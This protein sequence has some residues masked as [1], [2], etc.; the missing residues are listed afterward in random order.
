MNRVT[1]ILRRGLKTSFLCLVALVAI[2]GMPTET[3][4]AKPSKKTTA[5]G[6]K[7]SNT[8]ATPDFAFPQ[9]VEKNASAEFGKAMAQGDGQTALRAA[10]QLDV[11]TGLVSADTYA[12]SLA[13]FDS[14]ARTMPAPYAALARLLEARLYCDIYNSQSWVFNGR[15][16]PA[17]PVPDNVMEWSTPMF[18]EAVTSL[19]HEAMAGAGDAASTPLKSIDPL[20]TD[21]ADAERAGFS[22]LDFMTLQGADILGTFGTSR[23]SAELPFGRK[24]R[25]AQTPAGLAMSLVDDA[26]ARHSGDSDLFIKS[27]FCNARLGLLD[28]K[29]RRNYLKKCVD[30]FIDTPYCARF[31]ADYYSEQPVEETVSL[32]TA[33]DSARKRYD[34][35]RAYLDKYPDAP[36]IGDIESILNDMRSKNV[37]VSFPDRML[38]GRV[39]SA[40]VTGANSY[41][42]HV[43][44]LALKGNDSEHRY[45]YAD[46]KSGGEIVADIP[47]NVAGATPDRF[48]TRIEIPV[49]KPGLYTIVASAN[50]TKSGILQKSQRRQLPV[51]SISDLTVIKTEDARSAERKMYVVSAI[52][53]KP[54]AGAKVTFYKERNGVKTSQSVT[55][56]DSNGCVSVPEGE[57][58]YIVRSGGSMVSGNY[59]RNSPMGKDMNVYLRGSAFTD[60]S[61]YRPGDKVQFS[62]VA[63]TEQ[64]NS[65]KAAAGRRL[66]VILRDAN[67]QEVDTLS[68]ETD[69]LGRA[70]GSFTLPKSGLLGNWSVTVSE[71][72]KWVCNTSMQVAEY[73][74]PT[75]MVT[76]DS[77]AG[78]YKAGETLLFGGE[79][80]TYSGMP[81]AGGK[82]AY[83]VEYVPMWWRMSASGANYGG[84]TETGADG[85]FTIELPTD[86]LVGTEYDRGTYR[87]KVSVTDAAGETREAQAV[88]FSLGNE[89]HILAKLPDMIQADR[90][91]VKYD[92][93]VY[94]MT[95]RPVVK[96]IYYDITADGK[97]VAAGEFESPAFSPELTSVPSG[98]YAFR[99]SLT[100]D[101]KGGSDG[102]VTDSVTVW[103][104]D[105]RR[106]PVRTPLWVPVK[107]ITVPAGEKKVAVR[108][109]SSYDDSWLLVQVSDSRHVISNKWVKVSDGIV[110]IDVDAP[111]DRERVF[112][113]LTGMRDLDMRSE[114][115]TVIPHAQTV[116]LDIKAE[117][118][119]DRI[120]PGAKETWKFRFSTDG[121]PAAGIAD[122]AVMSNKALN[123]LA[124]FQWNF[125]PMGSLYWGNSG[126]MSF[127]SIYQ[128][129]SE[130]YAAAGG[131]VTRTPSFLTPEWNTYGY[132]LYQSGMRAVNEMKYM[133]TSLRV[134]G[135]AKMMDAGADSVAATE[136][137]P[138]T[139]ANSAMTEGVEE[140]VMAD[141]ADMGG[142]SAPKQGGE[143][144]RQ[145]EC[146]LAFFM[147][148]LSTDSQGVS[149]LEFT[150]PNFVGT[151][152][153]QVL[154]YTPEM[155]GGVLTLDAVSAKKV[156]AQ[157]NAPRFAR[158]GDLLSVSATIYNNT[159]SADEVSGRLEFFNPMT[160]ETIQMFDAEAEQVKASGSRVVTT[161]MRI[162]S[163]IDVLGIRVYGE[164]P[165]HTDGEQT[166]IPV[167]PSSTP[168]IESTPFYI[169]P[170]AKDFSVKLPKFG[171][172]SK[173]TLTYSDN[174]VWECV[175][176]LPSITRPESVNILSHAEALYGNAVASGL[177]ARYPQ[178]IEGI[179]EMASPVNAADSS[180]YSPLQKNAAL[181]TVL[182]NNTPWVNDAKAETARMQ[183]LTEYADT[184]SARA[185]VETI[186]KTIT[187]RQNSDGGWS[188]CPEMKSSEFITMRVLGTF[189]SLANMGYLPDGADR[190][191]KKG[192][193][194]VDGCLA[195]DW[196]RSERKYIPVSTLLEYLYEKSAFKGIGATSAFKPLEAAAMKEISKNW[197]DFGIRDKATAAMLLERRGETKLARLILESLR[198]FA[199]V[200]AEKG[201]WYDNLRSGHDGMGTLLM[202]ARVLEAYAMLEPQSESVDLLR[203]WFVVTKQTQNWGDR[204]A[205]AEA[206]QA[207]LASGSEWTATSEAPLITLGG[208]RVDT[209]RVSSVTGSFTVDLDAEAASDKELCVSRAGEGPAWGGVLSQYIAPITEVKAADVPQ[210][211]IAKSIYTI[212]PG[213][214]GNKASEGDLSTGDRVRV[215]LT[216]TC[217]RDLE[218][219][220][221]TDPR[222]ACLEPADQISSYTQS[223]GVWFYRE[224]RD[225]ATNLFIPFLSKGTHV[226][227]Y[228]CLTDRSGEY[229]LGVANA[230]SQYAPTITAHS[231]GSLISVK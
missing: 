53:Q 206:I 202:T 132:M 149:T 21:A 217:D 106:P 172:G 84:E 71:G 93:A 148:G 211:S 116:R 114:T 81:V 1:K 124:P 78:S 17:T 64:D 204:T 75:F 173:V 150:A 226:I 165:G 227:S 146:P 128:V 119:R 220:A 25:E 90:E 5:R 225:S 58:S 159:G 95:G 9:T 207:V 44:V 218:Y 141:D 46:L 54:V 222:A 188:W 55:T 40:T 214:A 151:W 131:K 170:A 69:R 190:L 112:V 11:A 129:S 28:G 137:A 163:D 59:Y 167:L 182:L 77:A 3:Y 36:G 57:I 101:L 13:R 135:A 39:N 205:S 52:N 70:S 88:S 160:G 147:P 216:I 197:R 219:V 20:L 199:S 223:D 184:E 181:K 24:A 10:I 201:M 82:V 87:L 97:S 60:L 126:R 152:Q 189:A 89:L 178:L 91:E 127:K 138:A 50:G 102:V 19:V 86:G 213:E 183:S 16:L 229:T 111:A 168:V 33:N 193:A 103:R 49:L 12:A 30:M 27:Y 115:V 118:F 174:P 104:A 41:G 117:T 109:G 43:L 113:T 65:L 130:Y 56:T 171:N 158:T 198:Q 80:K 125:D 136:M 143:P 47:V 156:M 73:K 45:T 22:V 34:A 63:Y 177:F 195:E 155:R 153:L 14:V 224:V 123:A 200:S 169:A 67:W 6:A 230:Q 66:S 31:L 38:P 228:D 164:I 139:G 134:R 208:K 142:S 96:K 157:L 215:T 105:D 203:Q 231:A 121:R 154:G 42:F 79:A 110:D 92:V 85:R 23:R 26:I 48:E 187:E 98:R 68:V 7:V 133:S 179:K 62:V 61:I 122:M 29:E 166:I 210:L 196:N 15:T 94:D 35:L 186:M 51:T 140:E 83:T 8:F 72:E 107:S 185:A 192:F 176:A 32:P 161:E 37:T 221:V 194:Y 4:A 144:L 209:G 175:T 212:T 76:M 120:E 99:F 74:S 162:P 18:S 108:V 180:L 100:P 145:V 191:A 2:S